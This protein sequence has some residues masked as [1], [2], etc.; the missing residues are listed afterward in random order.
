MKLSPAETPNFGRRA[1]L[2]GLGLPFDRTGVPTRVSATASEGNGGSRR[3][4]KC[5]A[6][7]ARVAGTY[8]RAWP[9]VA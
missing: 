8:Q 4:Y 7:V 9:G 2:S 6:A 5:V 3:R 1:L